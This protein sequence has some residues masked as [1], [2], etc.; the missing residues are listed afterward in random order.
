[1]NRSTNSYGESVQAGFL[2]R[3]DIDTFGSSYVQHYV[4]T[5]P[6]LST[7]N[8]T[9]HY[10]HGAN[11][12]SGGPIN[13]TTNRYTNR[14]SNGHAQHDKLSFDSTQGSYGI[15]VQRDAPGRGS[16]YGF[17]NPDMQH[18]YDRVPP[19]ASSSDYATQLGYNPY[20]QPQNVDIPTS[21]AQHSQVL[22]QES[23]KKLKGHSS[24]GGLALTPAQVAKQLKRKRTKASGGPRDSAEKLA[25]R[26]RSI[27]RT[28]LNQD[29]D[30]GQVDEA[31]EE[32]SGAEEPEESKKRRSKENNKGETSMIN[33]QLH[34]MD[35]ETGKWSKLQGIGCPQDCKLTTHS[36]RC[37]TS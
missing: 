20:A 4:Q 24:G 5:A 3:D 37:Q 30:Y 18:D 9:M 23:S 34:W 7:S 36:T 6:D 27:K 28:K 2:D 32:E 1:M 21:N 8:P 15:P 22:G 13:D 31:D 14:F 10:T 12:P 35:P 26:G 19:N 11:G 16:M 29:E 33:G 25:G 17:E